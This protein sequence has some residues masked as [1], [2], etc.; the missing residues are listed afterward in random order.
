MSAFSEK[1]SSFGEDQEKDF[2]EADVGSKFILR[3]L[4][5]LGWD[6]NNIDEVK[7]QKRTVSGP[8]DYSLN[9]NKRPTLLLELKSFNES[10][11]GKRVV[12]GKEET[13]PEQAIRYAWNLRVDWVILTNFKEIRLYYSH[14]VRPKD[15][16]VF[17]VK[18]DHFTIPAQLRRLVDD[19]RLAD[20][21]WGHKLSIRAVRAS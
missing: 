10:L 11:D 21:T 13:Y 6:I 19:G 18:Y 9:I 1:T 4:E 12:R 2:S 17:A 3:M 15:G 7:E 5:A 14:V 8:V 20:E 16:L